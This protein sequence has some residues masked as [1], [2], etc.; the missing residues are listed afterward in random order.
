MTDSALL[1]FIAQQESRAARPEVAAEQARAMDYYLGK[2]MGNE[3]EGRSSVTSSD[4]WDVVEGLAPLILKPFVSS[5]DVVRFRPTGPEDEDA[6]DQETDYINFVVTQ[7]ND[8]FEQLVTWVKAGLLQK[9]GVVKYWWDETRRTTVEMYRGKTGDE[10][11]ALMDDLSQQGE[12][13]ILE[14]S[15]TAGAMGVD[16]MGQ[17]TQGEP[18]HDFRVR[19]TRK[20]GQARYAVVP[21]EELLVSTAARSPNPKNAPFLEHVTRKT[22]SE[23]R[24]M[25]Y[26]VPD[27]ISDTWGSAPDSEAQALA[28]QQDTQRLTSSDGLGDPAGR[29]VWYREAY[30]YV[31]FDGDGVSEP[32]QI[33]MIGDTILANDEVSEWPFCGW[34]PYLQLFQYDGRCPADETIEIQAVKTTLWRQS[35]D[36]L[37][38]INNNRTF[39]SGKVN[40]DDM[41]D[42][43]IAGIVRIDGDVVGNHAMSMPITPI[44]QVVQPMIEYLDSAKENRTGFTRYNQGT[45]SNSL[46]KTAS[47][48]RMITEA[49]NE[50]VG[51]V[52]RSFAE[53]GLKPLMIGI[54][55]LCRSHATK[56]D[57]VRLRGRWVEIDPR[58]WTSRYD[59]TVSVGL[60]TADKQMQLQGQQMLMAE[61]KQLVQVPGLVT[62]KNLYQSAAKFAEILGEKDASKYFSDPDQA[63]APKPP[64]PMDDPKIMLEVAKTKQRDR[65][66]D[67]KDRE[68][69]IKDR[70]S[71]VKG[72]AD[73]ARLEAELAGLIPGMQ[74]I[75]RIDGIEQQMAM[76]QAKG[77]QSVMTDEPVDS[78]MPEA[79]TAMEVPD[80]QD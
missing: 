14:H 33:C 62:P 30:A 56:A 46:N 51:L 24:E 52:S 76:V 9:N 25:G 72:L 75:S 20:T 36:N 17:P 71:Q 27:D 78:A 11:A 7:R 19:L 48:I 34:T 60:G 8:V 12:V 57:T 42:N 39:V 67:Q 31:D 53:Q 74:V 63:E 41:L 64:D 22:L 69:D 28:R 49:G 2:P 32:R 37:Y 10:L 77:T 58:Q 65:E 79:M 18:L 66:L 45:D 4:V 40:L 54:H 80:G 21:P 38:T 59:M 61:Q 5:D 1:S 3:E 6:A 23:I 29:E 35:M 26:D 68:L 55:G 73:H 70:E 44:G 43:Q 15:E 16:E 47:G 50:R 13:K